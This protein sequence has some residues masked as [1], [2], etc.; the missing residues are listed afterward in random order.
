MNSQHTGPDP[1]ARPGPTPAGRRRLP[2]QR[3]GLSLPFALV[4]GDR[5]L[6]DAHHVSCQL[7]TITVEFADL[8]FSVGL[9]RALGGGILLEYA[10]R[11]AK[12]THASCGHTWQ[13]TMSG[14]PGSAHQREAVLRE[15]ALH[16][17]FHAAGSDDRTPWSAASAATTAATTAATAGPAARDPAAR[18]PAGHRPRRALQLRDP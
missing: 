9:S 8:R 3:R 17:G 5:R 14:P 4:I 1:G 12:G 11:Q 15:I 2:L 10:A 6:T 7:D 13:R 16:R 18:D